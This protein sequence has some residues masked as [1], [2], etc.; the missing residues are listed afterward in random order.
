MA[1]TADVVIIG[2]GVIGA[3]VAWHLVAGG[4]TNIVMLERAPR[5]GLG[6]TGKATGGV[7]AQ[8]TTPVN[9]AM[10]LHS[11]EFF[12]QFQDLT[13]VDPEYYKRGY[14]FLAGNER[15]LDQ[16][17]AFNRIQRECGLLDVE[18]FDVQTISKEIPQLYLGDIAG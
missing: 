16:L 6:S 5:Q 3:S 9:I 4:C 15:Q 14:L 1:E 12:E 10:S 7:R 2:A 18:F 11:L 17:R 8:F 13:G